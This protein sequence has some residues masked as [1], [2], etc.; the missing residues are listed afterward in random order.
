ME[1]SV[2]VR[3]AVNMDPLQ[4]HWDYAGVGFHQ[5]Y[6]ICLYLLWFQHFIDLIPMR[7]NTFVITILQLF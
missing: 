5:T 3:V 1:W 7:D 4:L 2:V 6:Q